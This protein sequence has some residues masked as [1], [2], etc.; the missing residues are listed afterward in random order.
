MSEQS[1]ETPWGTRVHGT[2]KAMETYEDLRQLM[3]DVVRMDDGSWLLSVESY[4]LGP[5]GDHVAYD[6]P[7]Q[8]V[9]APPLFVGDDAPVAVQLLSNL[10]ANVVL[11]SGQQQN[12]KVRAPSW[13]E[14][15][16]YG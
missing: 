1:G 16:H 10:A 4:V 8:F 2:R 15:K 5:L 6:P 12:S 3:V 13:G 11:W 7:S 14:Q 9:C